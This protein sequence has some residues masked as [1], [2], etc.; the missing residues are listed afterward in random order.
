ML[1]L[2]KVSHAT[3]AWLETVSVPEIGPSE[4]LIRVRAASICGTDLHIYLWDPW[5]QGRVHPPL[6][7]GHE[8]AGDVVAIGQDTPE[9]LLGQYVAAESHIA[10]G[11]CWECTHQLQHICKRVQ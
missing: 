8:F 6:I 9:S 10:C 2:L 4:V 1:A 7:F 5:A 3:G 11:E